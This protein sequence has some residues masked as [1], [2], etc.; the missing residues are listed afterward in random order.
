MLETLHREVPRCRLRGTWKN[1]HGVVLQRDGG[2]V[3]Q[4]DGGVVLQ[5]DREWSTIRRTSWTLGAFVHTCH[6]PF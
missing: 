1:C 3:L 5:R 6:F 4:R 2:V